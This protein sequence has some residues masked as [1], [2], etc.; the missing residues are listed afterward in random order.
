MT[1]IIIILAVILLII[2]A[3]WV[4]P[5]PRKKAINKF[6]FHPSEFNSTLGETIECAE[7]LAMKY[8]VSQVNQCI[9][10]YYP[11]LKILLNLFWW[12]GIFQKIKATN[13]LNAP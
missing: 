10:V 11:S 6:T 2:I 4:T 5:K 13:N 3:M 8:T 7:K 12:L 9:T 1:T